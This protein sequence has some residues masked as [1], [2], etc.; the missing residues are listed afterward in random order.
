MKN[1]EHRINPK[2]IYIISSVS[3]ALSI[4]YALNF[5]EIQKQLED[6]GFTIVNPIEILK[7]KENILYNYCVKDKLKKLINSDWVYI[8]P[9]V[10]LQ[11]GRNTEVAI[12]LELHLKIILGLEEVV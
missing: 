2:Y 1:N 3:Y 4:K 12:S 11:R 7:V 6:L 5:F 10:S 8:M 9:E